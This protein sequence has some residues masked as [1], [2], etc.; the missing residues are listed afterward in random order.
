M[1]NMKKYFI[2]I[3]LILQLGLLPIMPLYS[4][5]DVYM[6]IQTGGFQQIVISIPLFRTIY[7]TDLAIELRKVIVN[8][9]E[10]SGFFRVI[11]TDSVI[12]DKN[13]SLKPVHSSAE[14]FLEGE[15]EMSGNTMNLKANLKELP[16][17]HSIFN[18][19]FKDLVGNMRWLGH[20]V[21]DEICYYLIGERG[22]ASTRIVF[23]S[24]KGMKK[25][26]S[27][28]DYDGHNPRK[29]TDTESLNLSPTWSPGGNFLLFTS[30]LTGNPD[31][32]QFNM[33]SGK[34]IRLSDKPGLHSAPAWSPD[35]KKIAFTYSNQGNSDI[36]IMN[37][38]GGKW[39]K[40]TDSPAI[41]SSPS[42]SPTGRQIAFTSD[43]SGNPQV[44]IMDAE[45]GNI[46]RLT[47]EGKY[48][49]SP[50]WS[51]RGDLIAFASREEGHFQLYTVDVNGENLHRVTDG[52]GNNENP[53]WSP[54]GLKLAFAS[55]RNGNWDIYVINWDGTGLRR[56]TLT[57]QNVTPDWSPRLKSE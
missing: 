10:L 11:T 31:L 27:M 43:R 12:E 37:T 29:L 42:W 36:Y 19:E 46:R 49:D 30:Y 21:S 45:G 28:I 20:R 25:E 23:A 34:M 38:D 2:Q 6:K 18:K 35:G 26:I 13:S 53:S 1:V 44:Y 22:V 5:Q 24:G 32:L 55:D 47:F 40:L 33:G 56:I 3:L 16:A 15:L 57:G 41:E 39:K 7:P 17:G 50:A 54:D 4:Q 9:L 52:K 14:V 48:N 51:P 8:D